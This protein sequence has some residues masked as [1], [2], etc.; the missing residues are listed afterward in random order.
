M[1]ILQIGNTVSWTYVINDLNGEEII[2][3][4]MKKDC[5]SVFYDCGYTMKLQYEI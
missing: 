3:I 1:D 5:V 4:S 2:G